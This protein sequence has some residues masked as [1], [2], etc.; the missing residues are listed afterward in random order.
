MVVAQLNPR[1]RLSCLTQLISF[2]SPPLH[3][4]TILHESTS[5]TV[6]S[7]SIFDVC[8]LAPICIWDHTQHNHVLSPADDTWSI[9]YIV[10]CKTF[11]NNCVCLSE[12]TTAI[13]LTF[14]LNMLSFFAFLSNLDICS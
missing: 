1:K 9:N 10:C 12:I 5:W 8:G 3:H 11:V 14:V 4:S 6:K 7:Q 2:H 13:H